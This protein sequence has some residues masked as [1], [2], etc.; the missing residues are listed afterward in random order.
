MPKKQRLN[1]I[2]DLLEQGKAAFGPTTVANGNYQEIMS[3]G[4]SEY[5]FIILE[6]E[7][8]DFDF[9]TLSHSLHYLLNRRRIAQKGNLQPD[10]APLVRIPPNASEMN[11][12]I[13][14]QTLDLGAYGIVAPH[15]NTVEEARAIVAAMRYHRPGDS[16]P[17]GAHSG[18]RGSRGAGRRGVRPP[19]GG[20]RPRNITRWRTCGP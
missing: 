8:A 20:F 13:I 6:M 9:P 16:S 7:H 11:Q 2:I 5:D 14:K 12:W 1:K 3:I 15:V 19:T 18:P 17:T 4:E 10:V